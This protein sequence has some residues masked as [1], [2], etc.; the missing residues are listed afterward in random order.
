MQIAFQSIHLKL[1]ISLILAYPWQD[2]FRKKSQ[3]FGYFSNLFAI[4]EN[5]KSLVQFEKIQKFRN[6]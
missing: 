1:N 4:S 6:Y 5:S 2:L 3:C